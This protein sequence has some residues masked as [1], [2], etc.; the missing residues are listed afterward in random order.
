MEQGLEID[1]KSSSDS[2][3][4]IQTRSYE[5]KSS[6]QSPVDPRKNNNNNNN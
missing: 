6:E 2:D 5:I 3:E 1:S 4:N